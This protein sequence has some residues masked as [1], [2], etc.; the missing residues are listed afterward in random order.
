MSTSLMA[1]QRR[2]LLWRPTSAG[3]RLWEL[4]VRLLVA[5]DNGPNGPCSAE[6]DPNRRDRNLAGWV[7]RS[8]VAI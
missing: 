8:G 3:F 6:N 2:D 4:M 1:D 7:A 5:G